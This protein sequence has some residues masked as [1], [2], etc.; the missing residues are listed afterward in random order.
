MKKQ[1]SK[2][3][4]SPSLP[5][6]PKKCNLTL[7]EKYEVNKSFTKV[8]SK[9]RAQK[10]AEE[11]QRNFAGM[12]I[13]LNCIVDFSSTMFTTFQSHRTNEKDYY[14]KQFDLN[15]MIELDKIVDH[16]KQQD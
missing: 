11:S 15:K 8:Y 10:P 12:Y 3:L 5:R 6:V 1:Q 16:A 2:E 4:E 9:Y 13:N 14:E 7:H